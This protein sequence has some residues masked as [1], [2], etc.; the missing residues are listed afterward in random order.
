[1]GKS[2]SPS[3]SKNLNE[4]LRPLF[5]FLEKSVG[6]RWDDVYSEICANINPNKAIDYHV[7]QHVGWHVDLHNREE[8][9]YSRGG[10]LY[11]DDDGILR[12][13]ARRP[14]YEAPKSYTR[15]HWYGNVYFELEVLKT[16]AKCGCVHFKVPA[17]PDHN[18]RYSRWQYRYNGLPAVCIHG[19]KPVDRPIWYVVEY[20][21]HN[22]DEVYEVIRLERYRKTDG[23][24]APGYQYYGLSEENP[25]CK[26]YYRDRPD[27]MAKAFV[28]KKKTA[29]S[30]EL[31]LI[32]KAIEAAQAAS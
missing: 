15:F 23:T 5:Q 29:N 2:K 22:P 25:V 1:M 13:S 20:G 8:K 32:R 27:L 18:E 16:Y 21:Y 11:V 9:W 19:N 10:N 14:R 3:R 30:K 28:A 6:R 4:N 26:I 7:L 12:K 17:H 31:K 24:L